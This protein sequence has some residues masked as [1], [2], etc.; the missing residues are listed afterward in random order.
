[1]RYLHEIKCVILDVQKYDCGT[2]CVVVDIDG[3]NERIIYTNGQPDLKE[4]IEASI[5]WPF[6]GKRHFL[7]FANKVKRQL[8]GL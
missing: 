6:R 5:N 1:M 2:V 8:H 7:D 3:A 4:S